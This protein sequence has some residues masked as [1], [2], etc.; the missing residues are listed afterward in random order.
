MSKF[1]I[2]ARN[3]GRKNKPSSRL[4]RWLIGRTQNEDIVNG[5]ISLQFLYGLCQ[6]K[7]HLYGFSTVRTATVGEFNGPYC[8]SWRTHGNI[9]ILE[10]LQRRAC[11]KLELTLSGRCWIDPFTGRPFHISLWHLLELIWITKKLEDLKTVGRAM[12]PF[13]CITENN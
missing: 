7:E 10:P 12:H 5:Q 9:R 4:K 11:G 6:I 2:G 1:C 3:Q 8:P 13:K